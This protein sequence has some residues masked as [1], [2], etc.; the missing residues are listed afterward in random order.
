MPVT[1]LGPT[2]DIPYA[3]FPTLVQIKEHW[4]DDW[5]STPGLY[6]EQATRNAGGH[7][8]DAASFTWNYGLLAHPWDDQPQQYSPLAIDGWWV[9]VLLC[10]QSGTQQI[11]LGRISGEG[12]E[13]HGDQGGESGVQRWQAYGPQMILR[14]ATITQSVWLPP[15]GSHIE[16]DNW[17]DWLPGMNDRVGQ[18][19]LVIG[20]RSPN[21]YTSQDGNYQSYVFGGPNTWSAQDFVNYV[22]A[23]WLDFSHA[24]PAG[25][26][27]TLG[28]QA[29]LLKNLQF[30]Q[31][32]GE[33]TTADHVLRT[34]INPRLGVDF[35]LEYA[36]DGSGF[37]VNVFA[38]Q[39]QAV[40]AGD[41][42]LPA[43]PNT[44]RV[45]AGDTPANLSTH[46]AISN[47][48]K[49]SL[50]R[51]L[52]KRVVMTCTLA[53]PQADAYMGGGATATIGFG[54]PATL[55]TDYDNGEGSVPTDADGEQLYP[56][57]SAEALDYCRRDP[58]YRDVYS[59]WLWQ[60]G[61]DLTAIKAAVDLDA[62]GNPS[63]GTT[64][65]DEP[66]RQ[67]L[68]RHT[69]HWV[70]LRADYDYSA[71]NGAAWP[72]ALLT[73]GADPDAT[74][75][76]PGYVP[77]FLPPQVFLPDTNNH[78]RLASMAGV[79]VSAPAHGLGVRLNCHPRHLVAASAFTG[80]KTLHQ[81]KWDAAGMLATLAFESD[82]RLSLE[83]QVPKSDPLDG[84][85]EIYIHDAEM[86]LLAPK[87]AVGFKNDGSGDFV[88]SANSLLIL[89]DDRPRLGMVLAGAIARYASSRARAEV[90]AAGICPWGG[91]LGQIMTTVESGGDSTTVESPITQIQWSNALDGGVPK[92]TIRTGF[93]SR[94]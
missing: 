12:R 44:V 22:L 86:W 36:A 21:T 77:L 85:Q 70:P 3:T 80:Q 50:I 74:A 17:L 29:D 76:D 88:Q 51:V 27:F 57:T 30:A 41:V 11:W 58:R 1:I 61:T 39:T 69:L 93:A 37:T 64:G 90:T 59:L 81:P 45:Q 6:L 84:S 79:H 63:L 2:S 7:D 26:K 9:Q 31:E 15:A 83:Y 47:D 25:P 8:L 94:E 18:Q 5:Q 13:I 92:T 73:E 42:T 62:K 24:D 60:P 55:Q 34:L 53:G 19:A 14:K 28:G 65:S 38:L 71:W 32:W 91:L 49:V 4:G 87:T 78:Y 52:G 82:V 46:V 67:N 10:S 35:S 89:R 33:V 43:N 23:W 75:G 66:P 48:H 72:P 20:N 54:W 40:S 56:P 68:L 16:G